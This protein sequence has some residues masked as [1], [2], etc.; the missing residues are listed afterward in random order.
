MSYDNFFDELK[1][2]QERVRLSRK[3]V[4]NDYNPFLVLRRNN[5]EVG[6]HS[7]ILHS[8]LNPKETHYQDELFLSLFLNIA[9]LEDW[10]GELGGA[11]VERE[12]NNMDL[13]ITNG[14]KH[15][16]IEN[17][18]NARDG[19]RQIERYIHAL[20]HQRKEPINAPTDAESYIESS[21]SMD[22]SNVAVIYL[23]LDGRN[24]SDYSLGYWKV[25][26]DEIECDSTKVE[27][28]LVRGDDKVEFRT[29]SYKSDILRWL[30]KCQ[31][32]MSNVVNLDMSI[33]FYQDVVEQIT[34]QKECIMSI[35]KFLDSDERYKIAF[36]IL[37]NRQEIERAYLKYLLGKYE[38]LKDWEYAEYNV[39]TYL[40]HK[41][42]IKQIFKYTLCV[43]R[44][45]WKTTYC[46]AR[47]IIGDSKYNDKNGYEKIAKVIASQLNTDLH[48]NITKDYWWLKLP[49]REGWDYRTKIFD[50]IICSQESIALLDEVN[51]YLQTELNKA[52]SKIAKLAI[53]L[54]RIKQEEGE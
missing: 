31:D 45:D 9:G 38:V 35:E 39:A 11:K 25:K 49:H 32:K 51:R 27:K 54:V 15:I 18:V 53:D 42:Y 6:L 13:Y 46:G 12:F 8:L 22:Y 21:L 33:K 29:L 36:E 4:G 47:L 26:D 34:N 28:Y 10:F 19:E 50:E 43:Y 20:T 1:G 5:D 40:C 41:K 2:F 14:L 3:S 17:K 48:T 37:D 16:I 23:S 44:H 24:P 30:K 52:D 7:I